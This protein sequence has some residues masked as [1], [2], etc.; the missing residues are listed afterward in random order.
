MILN[1]AMLKI[2]EVRNGSSY[3]DIMNSISKQRCRTSR[4]ANNQS[5]I[6]YR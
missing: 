4:P 5:M 6:K 3:A 1:L 2:F